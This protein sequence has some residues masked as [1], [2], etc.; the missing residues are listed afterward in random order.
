MKTREELEKELADLKA[1]LASPAAVY[2][3][4]LRGTIA[5]PQA[6]VHYDELKAEVPELR[7]KL[8]AAEKAC[9]EMREA[10]T[11]CDATNY[12]AWWFQRR[13]DALA[14]TEKLIGQTK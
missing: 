11:T 9:A 10:L 12:S 6:L 7:A 8:E 5:K 3:N 14:L 2:T 1:I 13:R 4:I